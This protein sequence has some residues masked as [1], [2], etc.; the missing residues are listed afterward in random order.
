MH[1]S[2]LRNVA[3]VASLGLGLSGC[4]FLLGIFAPEEKA[5]QEAEQARADELAKAKAELE[6]KR[7]AALDASASADQMWEY[8]GLLLEIYRT[9][10]E[11]TL[12]VDPSWLPELE[13]ALSARVEG[14]PTADNAAYAYAL[15]KLYG[16]TERYDESASLALEMVKAGAEGPVPNVEMMGE[17]TGYPASE[18]TDAAILEMCPLVRP[19]LEDGNISA[20]VSRCLARAGGDISKLTWDSRLQDL[21]YYARSSYAKGPANGTF[22]FT[23][24]LK[25]YKKSFF[26]LGYVENTSGVYLDH[27]QVTAILTD[28]SG[29]EVATYQGYAMVDEIPPG[30]RAPVS[31]L[32]SDPPKYAEVRYE[33]KPEQADYLPSFVDD[34]TVEALQPRRTR[35][36]WKVEGKVL[37]AAKVPAQFV[38]VIVQ[39]FDSEGVLIGATSTYADGDKLEPGGEARWDTSTLDVAGKPASFEYIVTARVAD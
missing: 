4:S 38:K 9:K 19:A 28:N 37:S 26:A 11:E 17:I 13:A 31:V 8:A 34:L 25:S 22:T 29:A 1:I 20:F 32:V 35:F 12:G 24:K 2:R 15:V 16:A 27:A 21:A 7:S 18:T 36:G 33:F 6:A 14:G 5:K 10:Q 3:L 39:A 30:M 23:A